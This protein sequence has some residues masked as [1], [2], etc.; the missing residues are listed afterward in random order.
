M[1]GIG[2]E[3]QN[4][5]LLFIDILKIMRECSDQVSLEWFIFIVLYEDMLYIFQLILD[6]VA[7]KSSNYV[8]IILYKLIIHR[9]L[10]SYNLLT[11]CQLSGHQVYRVTWI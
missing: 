10:E 6:L 2:N 5:H 9:V 7:T 1:K 4:V 11:I 3:K 8:F